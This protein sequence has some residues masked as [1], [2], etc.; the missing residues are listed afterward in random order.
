MISTSSLPGGGGGAVGDSSF[1][2]GSSGR[3]VHPSHA[4]A[5]A[6]LATD[7]H[8]SCP[9]LLPAVPVGERGW[10]AEDAPSSPPHLS[11]AFP[12][13]SFR[14]LPPPPPS[15]SSSSSLP[16]FLSLCGRWRRQTVMDDHPFG[17]RWQRR[18]VRTTKKGHADAVL[19]VGGRRL[20]ARRQ[21]A[22]SG[23]MEDGG[24]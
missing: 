4:G 6:L 14:I 2:F 8:V 3:G 1:S 16:P 10:G 21:P 5:G 23:V 22:S 12:A 13:P 9:P 20:L 19:V 15:S 24:R 7:G 18:P 17:Q 11:P